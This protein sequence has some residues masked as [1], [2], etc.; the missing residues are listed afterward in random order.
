MNSI[1]KPVVIAATFA[2][3]MSLADA[4]LSPHQLGFIPEAAAIIRAP[5]ART[6]VVVGTTSAVASS[7]A[8]A[9]AAAQANAT[10]AANA[11]AAAANANAAAAKAP[12]PAGPPAV[13]SMTTTLPAGCTPTKLNG[14]DY[15]RC[16]STYYKAQMQ[17]N[18][19][20]YLVAQP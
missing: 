14:V 9:N 8:N 16:G 15:Q 17:G 18:N 6:A 19:L 2:A 20:V 4:P 7:S 11:N 12:A 1:L 10:A 5:V 13:G 3:L